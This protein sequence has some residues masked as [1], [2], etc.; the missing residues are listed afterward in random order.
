MQKHT[1]QT[2]DMHAGTCGPWGTPHMHH[3]HAETPHAPHTHVEAP[4]TPHTCT[5]HA[6]R[7]TTH[8]PHMHAEA[9]H[10]NP[11][12][13]THACRSTTHETCMR[14]TC[15]Q[16]HEAHT[17]SSPSQ[18]KSDTKPHPEPCETTRGRIPAWRWRPTHMHADP[19]GPDSHLWQ[20]AT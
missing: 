13:A 1:S 9:L 11:A 8:A 14:H 16:K 17:T 10:M 20:L 18:M 12:C 3:M 2:R 4:H 7:S 6:C 15:M 5:T 19:R